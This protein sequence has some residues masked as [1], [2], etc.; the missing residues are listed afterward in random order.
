MKIDFLNKS[1]N[2][3]W[4]VHVELS[5]KFVFVMKNCEQQSNL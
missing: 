1:L 2:L 5:L 3:R 4:L